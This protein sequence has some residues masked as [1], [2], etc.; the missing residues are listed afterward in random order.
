MNAG[1]Q[2]IP[3]AVTASSTFALPYSPKEA[4]GREDLIYECLK[5]HED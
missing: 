5:E 4:D 3:I 1:V 2:E